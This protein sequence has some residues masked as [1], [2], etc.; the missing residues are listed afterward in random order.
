MNDF[1]PRK[2]LRAA[3]CEAAAGVQ[4][5]RARAG[6]LCPSRA[7]SSHRSKGPRTA[8][9]TARQSARASRSLRR[10][11]HHGGAEHRAGGHGTKPHL[12]TPHPALRQHLW[13]LLQLAHSGG[14]GEAGM[15]TAEG[16]DWS[17]PALSAGRG[18][19]ASAG[20]DGQTGGGP[21]HGVSRLAPSCRS[22]P[23]QWGR[24]GQEERQHLAPHRHGL[25][26]R[27]GTARP[28]ADRHV[29]GLL[30]LMSAGRG[31]E[32]E[33]GRLSHFP[34]ADPRGGVGRVRSSHA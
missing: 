14:G 3:T 33:P 19:A 34:K 15:D 1:F 25:P 11:P 4:H 12:R 29:W 32:P 30:L 2:R 10:P 24:G 31:C 27:S 23:G 7:A 6:R 16:R 8:C 13:E 9:A 26:C 5:G 21:G 17:K 18:S 28:C 22:C 20:A